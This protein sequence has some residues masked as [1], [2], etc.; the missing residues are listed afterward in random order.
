MS[1][2]HDNIFSSV[3][4]SDMLQWLTQHAWGYPL[5]MHRGVQVMHLKTSK[6]HSIH[7]WLNNWSN[8][9]VSCWLPHL[10]ISSG[11]NQYQ[12]F[13]QMMVYDATNISDNPSGNV[14]PVLNLSCSMTVR[15]KRKQHGNQRDTHLKSSTHSCHVNRYTRR[16]KC[17][18]SSSHDVE[19]A[20]LNKIL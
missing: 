17:T 5:Y 8:C 3:N 7:M 16:N 6:G 2:T 11:Y 15:T 20:R 13:H 10:Y 12:M 18:V 14:R 1:I 19:V 4:R 9:H